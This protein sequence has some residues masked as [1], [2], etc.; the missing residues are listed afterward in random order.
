V[1]LTN[2]SDTGKY[3]PDITHDFGSHL[4]LGALLGSIG[5]VFTVNQRQ[6]SVVFCSRNAVLR[7]DIC[8]RAQ[9]EN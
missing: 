6:L 7:Q 4:A 3:E 2:A 1:A 8:P 5:P 9:K